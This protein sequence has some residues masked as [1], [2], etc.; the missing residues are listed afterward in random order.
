MDRSK[1]GEGILEESG[2]NR[3]GKVGKGTSL[4]SSFSTSAREARE[5]VAVNN[6]G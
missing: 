3:E 2:A 6:S 1:S 5:H 4:L